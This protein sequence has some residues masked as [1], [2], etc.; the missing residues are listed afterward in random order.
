[1]RRVAG[2]W[3]SPPGHWLTGPI[4][5]KS[6]V[7]LHLAEGTTLAFSTAPEDYLPLV[8]TRFEGVECMNY[9]PLIYAF[10]EKNIA[11][12]GK[13]VLDGQAG[14]TAWWNWKGKGLGPNQSAARDKLFAMGDADTPVEE[15]RFGAGLYLRPSFFEPYR[16][17]QVMIEGVTIRNAPFWEVHPVLCRDVIVCG[18]TI[19]STG[20]NTD[21]CD[22]E[23]CQDMLIE[24]CTFN[25]G[26]DCIAIKS[27]RNGDGR[28]LHTP[29][30]NVVIRNCHMKNGHGGVSI[31]SEITGGVRNVF[32]ENCRMDSPHLDNAIRIKNNA[33]RGGV[34]ENIH[35]RN[36]VIG[37]IAHAVL[38]VHF[39][40]EEA[41]NGPYRPVLRNL[42]LENVVS[43]K[44]ETALDIRGLPN[45]VIEDVTLSHCELNGVA[46]ENTLGLVRNLVL[47]DVKINGK[48]VRA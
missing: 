27:G 34:L 24:D 19:D 45:G 11:V 35:F 10:E 3:W 36:I 28:R 30:E 29:T 37:E 43:G 41:G 44:S 12:T 9:S 26:D 14:D 6:H 47:H 5:L 20:P 1:M 8:L 39:D 38:A 31:G 46:K 4:H 22:P 25:T 33:V 7:N 40:Y 48:A 15:R 23:S 16:C 42:S 17:Q 13:G 21:G 2:A 18:L 32:V